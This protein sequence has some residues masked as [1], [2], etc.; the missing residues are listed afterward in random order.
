MPNIPGYLMK[1]EPYT[2]TEAQIDALNSMPPGLYFVCYGCRKFQPASHSL[3]LEIGP[4]GAGAYCEKC[5][6]E[7]RA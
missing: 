7:G 4:D 6:R 5:K 2:L 3:S 1:E